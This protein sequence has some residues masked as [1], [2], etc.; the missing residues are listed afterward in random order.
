MKGGNDNGR[1]F[2]NHASANQI[3]TGARIK[4]V[5]LGS[6]F[7][8]AKFIFHSAEIL[9][10]EYAS[11]RKPPYEGQLLTIVGFRPRLKNNV[12]VRHAAGDYSLMPLYMVEKALSLKSL[13]IETAEM[14]EQLS[15]NCRCSPVEQRLASG[16]ALHARPAQLG[17]R[18]N[19]R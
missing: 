19:A 17:G 2:T 3:V 14:V 4:P 9:G 13:Q 10:L 5:V 18:Q 7:L 8:G 1:D 11:V 15:E 12:V 6:V 16:K